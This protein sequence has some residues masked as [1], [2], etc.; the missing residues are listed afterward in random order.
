MSSILSEEDAEIDLNISFEID[1]DDLLSEDV[2]TDATLKRIRTL[3]AKPAVRELYEIQV[4]ERRAG[5]EVLHYGR[6]Q[7][8]AV[9]SI[10][11]KIQKAEKHILAIRIKSFIT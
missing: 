8:P 3:Y 7:L 4:S 2:D 1:I 6:K 11:S 10:Q 5:F 9:T